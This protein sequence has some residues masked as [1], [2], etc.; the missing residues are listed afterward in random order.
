MSVI[1][2][3]SERDDYLIQL[4]NGDLKVI[5]STLP[6]RYDYK[7]YERLVRNAQLIGLCSPR[8]KY[9]ANRDILLKSINYKPQCR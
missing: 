8:E 9:C 6:K 3:C 2:A 5:S 4:E 1:S 7:N